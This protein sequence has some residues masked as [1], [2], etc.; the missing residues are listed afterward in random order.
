MLGA[1]DLLVLEVC[2]QSDAVQRSKLLPE[3]EARHAQLQGDLVDMWRRLLRK[4]GFQIHIDTANEI[5]AHVP[6]KW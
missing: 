3:R 5:A 6:M 2:A 4:A 1:G